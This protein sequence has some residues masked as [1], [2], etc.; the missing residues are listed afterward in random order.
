MHLFRKVHSLEPHG[1][2]T[3]QVAGELRR[4]VA[5]RGRELET[6]LLVAVAAADGG[7]AVELHQL[8]QLQS[9]LLEQNLPDERAERVHVLAQGLVLRGKVDVVPAHVSREW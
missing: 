4:P 8:E 1:E 9:A 5:D 3:H 6:C 2:G 7:L